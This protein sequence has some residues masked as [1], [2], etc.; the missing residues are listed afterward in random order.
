MKLE[1]QNNKQRK[2]KLDNVLTTKNLWLG[3][4]KNTHSNV[5]NTNII[6]YHFIL[7]KPI[8]VKAKQNVWSR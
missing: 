4:Y 2:L 6:T 8:T 1:P 7:Y 5:K 3:F